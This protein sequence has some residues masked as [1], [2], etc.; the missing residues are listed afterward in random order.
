[1]RPW[2]TAGAMAAVIAAVTT[3]GAC[4]GYYVDYRYES[5]SGLDA[6][7]P[8][9]PGDGEPASGEPLGVAEVAAR[10]A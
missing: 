8:A 9:R 6:S 2:S 1:M 4:A 10:A 7:A 3:L 5:P